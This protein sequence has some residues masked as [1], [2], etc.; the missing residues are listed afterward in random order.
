MAC[1]IRGIV[2]LVCSTRNWVTPNRFCVCVYGS[3]ASS[4]LAIAFINFQF[5]DTTAL[6]INTE[7]IITNAAL[8][9]IFA[10]EISHTLRIIC[11][12]TY[13]TGSHKARQRNVV[14]E[15]PT[16]K[17]THILRRVLSDSSLAAKFISAERSPGTACAHCAYISRINSEMK[18]RV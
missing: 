10:L 11:T 7:S 14:H 17:N 8:A 2:L 5:Y 13:V 4:L 6:A 18:L 15:M 12:Y 3:V 9:C 1:T 16:K